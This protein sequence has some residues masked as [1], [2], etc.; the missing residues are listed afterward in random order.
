MG[1]DQINM[2]A[3]KI[4]LILLIFG[5]LIGLVAVWFALSMSKKSGNNVGNK[6]VSKSE[7]PI[8]TKEVGFTVVRVLPS[9]FSPKEVTI[10]KGMIVRFTNPTDVKVLIKWEGNVQYSKELVFNGHDI[11]TSIF[12]KNGTYIYV[13]EA[14]H[15]GLVVVK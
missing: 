12:D 13:D 15:K 3:K 5:I 8:P 10:S 4:S 9:G 2:D 6:S 14:G 1:V 11:A 7:E